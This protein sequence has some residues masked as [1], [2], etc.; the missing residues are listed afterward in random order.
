M[1]RR[2]FLLLI[3]MAATS[4][5]HAGNY[6]YLTFETTKNIR[7][8]VN[9]TSLK[10]SISGSTL[11]V[12]SLQFR[13]SKLSK[14]YFSSTDETTGIE[15]VESEAIDKATDIYDL[16]GHKVTKDQM[17]KGVYILRAKDKTCKLIVK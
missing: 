12:D 11:I 17:K 3:I 9:L 13:L 8:S 10:I 14:M 15:R 7:V 5:L 4:I 16:L 1:M 6:N 2:T